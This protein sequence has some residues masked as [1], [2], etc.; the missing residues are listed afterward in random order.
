M[1][2]LLFLFFILIAGNNCLAQSPTLQQKLYYTCKVWGFVKYYHSNVSS[3][4]VNWDSVLISTLPKIEDAATDSAFNDALDTMLVA[5]GPMTI[6]S[7][8]FPD[9]LAPDLKRNR[10]WNWIDSS[11]FRSDVQIQLDTIRNNFRPHSECWV[12]N[13]NGT[14]SSAS[15]LIF[16][17][18]DPGL[19][20]NTYTS[21]PDE[22]HRL[23]LL[24]KYWNIVNY[25]DPYTYVFDKPMDTILSNNVMLIDT[26]SSDY[27]FYL[28]IRKIASGFDDAHV[29]VETTSTY[30]PFTGS[31][32]PELMLRYIQGKYVVVKSGITAVPV[33]DAIISVNGLTTSQ[34]EDSLRN[35]VSAGNNSVFH[36][37]MCKC[38]LGGTLSSVVNIVCADTTGVTNS[39]PLPRT[40]PIGL[41]VFPKYF[42]P[43]DSLT[44]ITWTTMGCG[45]GY[46]N[47]WNISIA[48][49]DSAYSNLQNA[50]A[51]IVDIRN[52]PANLSAWELGNL[53][54]A[55][56]QM[57]SKLTIPDTSYPGTFSWAYD[58]LGIIG[59]ATPYTGT[60]I[61]LFRVC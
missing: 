3:C 40:T 26:V 4:H 15:W 8:Y 22:S 36:R 47:L 13:N 49:T 7:T 55:A 58:S 59:N 5:A 56:P 46:I 37:E 34:W 50:P 20:V 38:L 60:I 43:A 23:L 53:M 10:N 45:L 25:F 44:G 28:T 9:T 2:K 17:Y 48:G 18:D 42:Y 54:Y 31:Y 16:P 14:T 51:I 35:Y 6:S 52:Y 19:N 24:F 57:F 41:P 61:L 12:E 32:A 39:I 21:Y 29:E 27:R 33:G 11:S 1:R 30:Y